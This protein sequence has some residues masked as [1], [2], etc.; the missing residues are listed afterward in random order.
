MKGKI[1]K[2]LTTI[3]VVSLLPI[4]MGQ[5]EC[6]LT[7]NLKDEVAGKIKTS[8]DPS[9]PVTV[10]VAYYPFLK[11]GPDA[12]TVANFNYLLASILEKTMSLYNDAEA[13]FH[14]K[15]KK[16]QSRLQLNLIK[17][18]NRIIPVTQ[19]LFAPRG[20]SGAK[21]I[22]ALS[23]LL[24]NTGNDI[25]MTSRYYEDLTG[26]LI[27]VEIAAF[28]RGC[29][30]IESRRVILPK[31]GL[32][33]AFRDYKNQLLFEKDK[34]AQRFLKYEPKQAKGNKEL[35]IFD[36]LGPPI[37]H[38]FVSEDREKAKRESKKGVKIT[39][40]GKFK[41]AASGDDVDVNKLLETMRNIDAPPGLQKKYVTHLSFMDA[42]AMSSMADT[43]MAQLIDQAV[44]AGM[45]KAQKT[46]PEKAVNEKNHSL[47]NTEANVNRM[48]NIV[49]DPNR[50]KTEKINKIITQLMTPNGVDV[51]VTGHYIHDARNSLISVRPLIIVKGSRGIITKNLQYGKD[52]LICPDPVTGKRRLC[53]GAH[54]D[55]ARAVKELLERL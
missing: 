29:K 19:V 25:I 24:R 37:W 28:F 18:Q 39:Y 22:K 41:D 30:K 35:A 12:E 32:E 51:I 21:K 55:I 17:D 16:W 13:T 49:F 31:E 7:D 48:V 20:I 50:T 26:D 6:G 34:I 23:K 27:T 4:F 43:Q 8:R 33:E 42:R 52:E 36:K 9:K 40:S 10:N 2:L 38:F 44:M 53:K 15:N 5:D 45:K 54:D 1:A 14:V 11:A 46:N 47:A 3:V